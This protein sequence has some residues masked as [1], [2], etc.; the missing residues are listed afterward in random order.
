[1]AVNSRT[2][3]ANTPLEPGIR[4]TWFFGLCLSLAFLS[5]GTQSPADEPRE[6][7]SDFNAFNLE[8]GKLSDEV[9]KLREKV[10]SKFHKAEGGDK[11]SFA[12]IVATQFPPR[13][14]SEKLVLVRFLRKAQKTYAP[15]GPMPDGEAHITATAALADLNDSEAQFDMLNLARKELEERKQPP[16][17]GT[18]MLTIEGGLLY[19]H[20]RGGVVYLVGLL[21]SN[22]GKL[23]R[24]AWDI[25]QEEPKIK[26][27][28]RYDPDKAPEDQR[29]V[30]EQLQDLAQV[31]IK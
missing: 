27:K 20:A 6:K 16:G 25:L 14:A 7:P 28:F 22:H 19:L 15:G 2:R 29:Q 11:L 3:R 4:W 12:S 31:L 5:S 30:L 26:G 13:D 18:F 8:A 1:M 17:K 9:A 23:R 10:W 24:L 21:E